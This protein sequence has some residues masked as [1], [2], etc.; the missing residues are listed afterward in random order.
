MLIHFCILLYKSVNNPGLMKKEK[1]KK[2]S[3][4]RQSRQNVCWK[5]SY[6]VV[7][8]RFKDTKRY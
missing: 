3:N 5:L 2:K 8:E 6:C 4:K 1:E 7:E